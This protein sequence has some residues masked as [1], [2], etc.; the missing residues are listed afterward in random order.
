MHDSFRISCMSNRRLH[1]HANRLGL[2]CFITVLCQSPGWSDRAGFSVA[3]GSSEH[4]SIGKLPEG[5]FQIDL[6]VDPSVR[7]GGNLQAVACLMLGWPQDAGPPSL[8][9]AAADGHDPIGIELRE[10]NGLG[11]WE[12]WIGA[13]NRTAPKHDPPPRGWAQ[14]SRYQLPNQFTQRDGGYRLRVVGYDEEGKTRIELYFEHFDRPVFTFICKRRLSG[15]EAFVIGSLGGN[16]S[17]ETTLNLILR[18]VPSWDRTSTNRPAFETLCLPPL[19]RS[20]L[21]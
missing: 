7:A 16:R 21:A 1:I 20:I 4:H 11:S 5:D 18:P 10:G 2:A 8:R 15:T 12:V 13:E 3:T 14:Q 6:L 19:T 9:S 17:D